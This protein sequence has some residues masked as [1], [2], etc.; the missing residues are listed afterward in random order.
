MKAKTNLD[1]YFTDRHEY[2]RKKIGKYLKKTEQ[3]GKAWRNKN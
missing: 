1:E 3:H 2:L